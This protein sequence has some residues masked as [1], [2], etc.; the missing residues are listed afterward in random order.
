[1]GGD[2]LYDVPDGPMRPTEQG[3]VYRG[4]VA[5]S[6]PPPL[7][8]PAREEVDAAPAPVLP[9]PVPPTLPDSTDGGMREDATD[10]PGDA[11]P[12]ATWGTP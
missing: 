5:H 1:M 7:H 3:L 8:F 2:M 4:R 9:P 11:T 10:T 6:R 12:P